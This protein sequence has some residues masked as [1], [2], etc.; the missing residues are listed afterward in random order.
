MGED[1]PDRLAEV[2]QLLFVFHD[3]VVGIDIIRDFFFSLCCA[4]D[5]FSPLID[6]EVSLVRLFGCYSF[7]VSQVCI[8]P[9][10]KFKIFHFLPVFLFEDV[11]ILPVLRISCIIIYPVLRNLVN[12]EEGQYL[13]PFMEEGPFPFKMG[14]DR[15]ADLNPADLVFIDQASNLTGDNRDTICK[16]N[17]VRS[18]VNTCDNKSLGTGSTPRTVQKD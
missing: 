11:C 1:E 13:D 8:V 12:E 18:P 17:R 6:G 7:Q 14:F 2:E 3:E 5:E 9:E 16:R 4:V 15:L 10:G